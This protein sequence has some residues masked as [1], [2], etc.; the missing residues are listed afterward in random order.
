MK[1][2][3][4][5]TKSDGLTSLMRS[6]PSTKQAYC[7]DV[8]KSTDTDLGNGVHAAVLLYNNFIKLF[9]R[10]Y[11]KTRWPSVRRITIQRE[12]PDS[13]LTRVIYKC[14]FTCEIR[15]VFRA[16]KHVSSLSNIAYSLIHR[17]QSGEWYYEILHRSALA[18]LYLNVC[19]YQ[20]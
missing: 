18:Y 13:A 12:G 6:Q 8:F 16:P 7:F 10:F 5:M 20:A 19:S 15:C 2:D 14:I 3:W 9:L 1:V 17:I 11:D 4:R